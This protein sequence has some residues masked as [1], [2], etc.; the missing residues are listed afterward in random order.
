MIKLIWKRVNKLHQSTYFS[1]HQTNRPPHFQTTLQLV[2]RHTHH[3]L[4]THLS[5]LIP[6]QL[7]QMNQ[8][9]MLS[10]DT[11]SP[12]FVIRLSPNKI[13]PDKL[14]E[15]LID[16]FE[17]NCQK[18]IQL[19]N[20]R[21]SL[22]K[23]N[24]NGQDYL[25]YV[26]DAETFTLLL[27]QKK[28]PDSIDNIPLTFPSSPAIPPQ[29]SLLIKNVSLNVDFEDF[30]KD[31][32]G[33]YPDIQN[34]IRMK[35]KFQNN[36][37]LV[38]IELTST[39]LRDQLLKT[40]R[41]MINYI[42]YDIDE[43]LAPA[44][45]LICSKCQGIGHF[46]KQC[47]QINE[48][49]RICSEQCTDLKVHRC[50]MIEKCVHCQQNHKSSSFQCPVIKSYRAELTRK[51]L[52]TNSQPT[53]LMPTATPGMSMSY[54]QVN[55]PS[56]LQPQPSWNKPMMDKI[57]DLLNKIGHVNAQLE[58]ISHKHDRFEKFMNERI[59]RDETMDQQIQDILTNSKEYKKNQDQ[60]KTYVE[61]HENIMMKLVLSMF[62]DLFSLISSLNQDKKGNTTDS[63]LRSK[64]ESYLSQVK[65]TREGKDCIF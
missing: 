48:T 22:P 54:N 44:S 45:V 30:C 59:Q 62:D 21:S 32:K 19:I 1:L 29:L 42:T 20:C 58:N 13:N 18:T 39:I 60:M 65:K 12:P 7:S 4:H 49:C 55:F 16:H 11:L 56:L 53:P 41:I 17:N 47:K 36:I 24:N 57:D 8:R 3:M 10:P 28:W 27:D 9:D 43:Y 25:I 51:L 31:A 61:R 33:R 26:K 5:K 40:K 15:L 46:K 35:N 34:I 14:K 23:W 6:L 52:K 37:K 50:T 38:K 2:V 63:D 64:L